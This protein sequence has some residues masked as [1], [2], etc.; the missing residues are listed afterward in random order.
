MDNRV[1]VGG[2]LLRNFVVGKRDAELASDGNYYSRA[3]QAGTVYFFR[4]TCPATG[5]SAQ[6]SF[7][8]QTVAIGSTYAEP[9]PVD[10]LNPGDYAWPTLSYTDRTQQIIDPQT[11]VLLTRMSL[12]Q[13]RV[14]PVPNQSFVSVRTTTWLNASAALSNAD[15]N[16]AATITGDN[17]GTLLL[18]PQDN[19]SFSNYISFFAGNHTDNDLYLNWFQVVLNAATSNQSCP[20]SGSADCNIVVCLTIDGVNCNPN[21]QQFQQALS[22]NLAL[23]TFGTT[24]AAI[25]LW[26]LPGQRPF[27]GTEVAI[28]Q[29]QVTCDGSST[30]IWAS[31]DYFPTFWSTNSVITIQGV[32]YNVLQV[33][34][35]EN[36]QIQG[37]CPSTSGQPVAYNGMNF[38]VLVRKQTASPDTVSVEYAS[39]NYQSG[40]FPFFD[41]S[42][43]YDLCGTGTVVGP[44]GNPG[45]NC[46]MIQNGQIYW[47]DGITG[48]TQ[49]IALNQGDYSSPYTGS[50]GVFDSIPFDPSE[51]DIFY[52][53]GDYPQQVQYFGSHSD[54]QNPAAQGNLEEGVNIPTCNSSTPPTNQPCLAFT[55]LTGST[56]LSDLI[57]AFDPTFDPD[58]YTTNVLF[59]H[60]ENGLLVFRLWRS[61]Y[62]TLGWTVLFDPNATSNTEPNNAGCVGGGL[63]G[64]VVGAVPSWSRPNARWCALKSNDPLYVPGWMSTSPFGWGP[65]GSQVAGAG[66]YLSTVN[67]GTAFSLNLNGPGGPTA[68][69]PNSLGV[70]GD[71]CTT[72]SVDAQPYNPTPCTASVEACYGE[73]ESGAPGAIGDVAVG[74]FFMLGAN[75]SSSE[76][77]VLV[78]IGGAS[79]TQWTFQRGFNNLL[80]STPA[81]PQLYTVCNANPIPSNV[82]G[83]SEW[84][85]NYGVDPHGYNANG[86]TILNDPNGIQAHFFSQ[87]SQQ[88]SSYSLDPRCGP[89]YEICYQSRIYNS[90][91]ELLTEGATEVQETNPAF[92]GIQGIADGNEVQSHPAGPGWMAS[93]QNSPYFIDGRPFNGGPLSGSGAFN[94]SDPA[95]PMG[96]TLWRFSQAQVPQLDRKLMPT[97]AFSGS[98]ALLDV[99]SPAQG[100]MISGNPQ[101]WYKYCV[102]NVAN[103]CVAGS[104]Q[105][106]VYVNAPYVQYPY[107]NY[108][109]QAASMPDEYD[110]CV[111]DNAVIYNSLMQVNGSVTDITGASQ[112]SLGKGLSRVRETDAFWH[113][114][115]LANSNWIMFKT[116][117]AQDVGDM[118]FA[119]QLPPATTDS[120][121]RTAYEMLTLTAPPMVQGTVSAYVEFGYGEYGAPANLYCTTRAE[122]CAAGQPN[123]EPFWFDATEG[124][125]IQ[126]VPCSTGCQVSIPVAPQHVVYAQWVFFDGN[127]A[128]LGRSQVFASAVN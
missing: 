116:S 17:S 36:L 84:Y 1:T 95:T 3:L 69:P 70:S 85:W 107:C 62:G 126:P 6:G 74:D 19:V 18:L 117:Y 32:N 96:G 21:G 4:L 38:G 52:C 73:I 12:P 8:T 22:P 93:P 108:P 72:V 128:V 48:Q 76:I 86:Q 83:S 88:V 43:G 79:N 92:N 123:G 55:N 66:P 53:G 34:T 2:A 61:I 41:Y 110:L 106:D 60:V 94:G 30:V 67:D 87:N 51:P 124:S 91:S 97:F 75:S 63:P 46:S 9:P 26:Q 121:D 37:S 47:I 50:C 44:T 24:G 101:D 99:S 5:D 40:I 89:D 56:A 78:A 77:M 45:Y 28:R 120:V 58:A 64:C 118:I 100:N 114:H 65:I 11:G 35:T 15:G 20:G 119:M 90:L 71:Q 23:Y 27:N 81:D 10:P 7:T 29:G 127:G 25:D 31:G 54:A 122:V 125:E 13:D 103:E 98:K 113:A 115:A 59:S 16:Q 111:G 42:G 82:N 102:A 49:V 33:N 14:I 109:S 68:C 57:V 104:Q 80:A 39:A 112:R 105:G